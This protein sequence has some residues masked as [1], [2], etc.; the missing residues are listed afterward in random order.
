[1][2]AKLHLWR[3]PQPVLLSQ[4]SKF[5]YWAITVLCSFGISLIPSILFRLSFYLFIYLFF[6]KSFFPQLIYLRS[7]R[8]HFHFPTTYFLSLKFPISPFRSVQSSEPCFVFLSLLIFHL[9]WLGFFASFTLQ[10]LCV[11][12][13]THLPLFRSFTRFTTS[14]S[15]HIHY[16]QIFHNNGKK[17]WYVRVC[18]TSRTAVWWVGKPAGRPNQWWATSMLWITWSFSTPSKRTLGLQPWEKWQQ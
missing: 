13:P 12:Q 7:I 5:K 3:C 15:S 10:L 2:R 4:F 8:T 1:M 16:I 6:V 14:C 18:R 17:S 9:I 11:Y